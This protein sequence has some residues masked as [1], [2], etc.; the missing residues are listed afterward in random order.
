MC[1]CVKRWIEKKTPPSVNDLGKFDHDIVLPKP[2][3][4]VLYG[5]SSQKALFQ[6]SELF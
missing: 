3:I 2:G 4:M 6:I 5:K 1:A